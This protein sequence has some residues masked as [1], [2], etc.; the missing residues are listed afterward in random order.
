MPESNSGADGAAA[1]PD[2]AY[3]D[4]EFVP[5]EQYMSPEELSQ[6]RSTVDAA[7]K[8]DEVAIM[9]V[10]GVAREAEG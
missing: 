2:V 9:R 4:M 5:P 8:G 1:E 6:L 10:S 3:N 7:S